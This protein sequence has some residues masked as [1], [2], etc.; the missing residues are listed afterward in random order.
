METQSSVHLQPRLSF[1]VKSQ[2]EKIITQQKKEST[3]FYLILFLD[4]L[5][6]AKDYPIP[7]SYA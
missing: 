5:W 2:Q 3:L 7:Q 4:K 1:V 6:D